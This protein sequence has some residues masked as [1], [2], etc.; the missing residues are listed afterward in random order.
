MSPTHGHTSLG[1]T[2]AQAISSHKPV[3]LPSGRTRHVARGVR[4]IVVGQ[5]TMQP[6][7][8]DHALLPGWE[9]LNRAHVLHRRVELRLVR[10]RAIVVR[11]T[12]VQEGGSEPC[13]AVRPD[14]ERHRNS[15]ESKEDSLHVS[16]PR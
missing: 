5:L 12:V 16:Q 10:A 6:D 1:R 3:E 4:T 15:A 9:G 11:G 14:R 8:A 7:E 13:I 2:V